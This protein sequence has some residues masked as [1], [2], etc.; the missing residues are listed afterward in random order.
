MDKLVENN[1][2]VYQYSSQSG[3][4]EG[5]YNPNGSYLNIA[6]VCNEFGNVM[7]IMPHPEKYVHKYQHPCWTRYQNL[8]EE[9]EGLLIYR[10][11][12]N[13]AKRF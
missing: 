8:K 2:I 11:A 10:N 4:V 3:E 5:H 9:G 6:A 13:F 12:V 7:G 1:Q